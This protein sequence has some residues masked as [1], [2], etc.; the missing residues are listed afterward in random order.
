MA[1][2]L[3]RTQPTRLSVSLPAAPQARI[4]SL[5]RAVGHSPSPLLLQP[6]IH[7]DGLADGDLF[8]LNKRGNLSLNL[9][10][11]GDAT[12]VG[13]GLG[14]SAAVAF[15]RIRLGVGDAASDSTAEVDAP[16]STGGVASVLFSVRCF[17]GEVDSVGVPVSS[18]D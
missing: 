4:K 14:S 17:A 16:L 10:G 8:G 15:L 13:V 6:L 3:T 5:R 12:G 1:T 11:V 9:R 2:V 7:G 18:W